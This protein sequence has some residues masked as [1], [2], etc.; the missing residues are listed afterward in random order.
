[1]RAVS[2]C[3]TLNY[4][5]FRF[6]CDLP[7]AV[8]SALSTHRPARAVTHPEGRFVQ[9]RLQARR[10][11]SHLNHCGLANLGASHQPTPVKPPEDTKSIHYAIPKPKID[12]HRSERGDTEHANEHEHC[13]RD[14]HINLHQTAWRKY[15]HGRTLSCHQIGRMATRQQWSRRTNKRVLRYRVPRNMASQVG[16]VP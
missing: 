11:C 12:G 7:Q 4:A 8:L 6:L 2:S 16:Q 5:G 1:M 3:Y 13:N 9:N 15:R 10:P 14:L